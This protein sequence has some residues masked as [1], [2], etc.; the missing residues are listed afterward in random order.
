M[1]K[2]MIADVVG[3][4]AHYMVSASYIDFVDSSREY[5]CRYMCP[6]YVHQGSVRNIDFDEQ[7]VLLDTFFSPKPGVPAERIRIPYDQIY[8]IARSP[9]G[10]MYVSKDNVYTN[11]ANFRMPPLQ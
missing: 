7:G 6:V 2:Q 10:G 3:P 4:D 11:R 5:T 9:T 8:Q 1:F